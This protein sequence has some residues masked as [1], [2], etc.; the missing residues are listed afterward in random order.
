MSRGKRRRKA[1]FLC[2]TPNVNVKLMEEIYASHIGNNHVSLRKKWSHIERCRDC[3][4]TY[5]AKIN[6]I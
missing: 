2:W 5:K 6:L 1:R 3:S 4:A